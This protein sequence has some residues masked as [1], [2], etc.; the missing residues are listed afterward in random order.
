MA[1]RSSPPAPATSIRSSMRARSPSPAAKA[2]TR[3]ASP[4]RAAMAAMARRRPH[5]QCA[6]QS[7]GRA[8]R[9][10]QIAARRQGGRGDD[11]PVRQE[12]KGE[13]E[14]V[15]HALSREKPSSPRETRLITRCVTRETQRTSGAARSGPGPPPARGPRKSSLATWSPL[16]GDDSCG[17]DDGA[18]AVGRR[19]P[20]PPVPSPP[21]SP[22][23]RPSAA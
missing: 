1:A 4:R 14:A 12:A 13:A 22:P 15:G 6:R 19:S 11:R 2:A 16:R 3:A 20:K 17:L 5:P 21:A 8:I 18:E 7:R 9:G 23:P 10:H